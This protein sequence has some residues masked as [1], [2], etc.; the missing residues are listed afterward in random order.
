M[1]GDTAHDFEAVTSSPGRVKFKIQTE[2]D[3]SM[4]LITA[5]M[6]K[7]ITIPTKACMIVPR[8]DSIEFLSPAEVI[9][10]MPPIRK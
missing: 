7:T 1:T 10:F 3:A 8:A 4:I 2:K 6:A 9:H 5:N